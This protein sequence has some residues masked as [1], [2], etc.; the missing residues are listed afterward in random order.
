MTENYTL[1]KIENIFDRKYIWLSLICKWNFTVPEKTLQKSLALDN[2]K[3]EVK[4]GSWGPEVPLIYSNS[5][6]L[7]VISQQAFHKMQNMK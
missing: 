1:W 6:L 4:T 7:K 2:P 5:I 3:P